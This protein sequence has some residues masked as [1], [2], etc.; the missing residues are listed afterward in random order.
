MLAK[1]AFNL[2]E[3]WTPADDW[4]P[5]RFLDSPLELGSG[6]TATLPAVR[7][8]TMIDTYYAERGLDPQGR[9]LAQRPAQ[10]AAGTEQTI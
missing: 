5:E 1:R 4:L 8:R 10:T 2:R 9:P 7:L 3:G 6:R